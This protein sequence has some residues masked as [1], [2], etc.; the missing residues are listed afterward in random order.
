MARRKKNRTHLKGGVPVEGS[1][2]AN[3]SNAPKSVVV[4]HGQVG[5]ALSQLVRDLRKV[6]EPNTASK[7]RERK[8][9]KM[10]DYLVI[11]PALGVTHIVALTLTPVAPSLRIMRLSAGPTLSFRIERYSL[12]RDL[13][14]TSRHARS[15]GMEYLSPPLLVLASF[16]PPGPGTPPH[17]SLVQKFFQALFPPLSPHAIS[18][19]SA[20][21][22]VLISYNSETK[23][24]SIRH[25]LIGVRALGVTRHIRK[26][27]EGKA[28]ASHKLLDL[29]REKDLADYILRAPG[30]PGPDGYESASS[31]ASDID[32]EGGIAEVHLAGDYVGR[33]NRAGSKRAVKLT[34]I[35][36]R[37]ELRL[38]KIT[39]GVPGKQGAV[40]YHEFVKKTAAETAELKRA[41]AARA[42]LK[43]ER[44][45]QQARN[46]EQKK[47]AKSQ[48]SGKSAGEVRSKT[49]E[50]GEEEEEEEEEEE[51]EE[52]SID[53]EVDTEDVDEWDENDDVSEGSD[54]DETTEP[55]EDES[56]TE[57]PRPTKRPR[58]R[59]NVPKAKIRV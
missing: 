52:G 2:S 23:T 48:A 31:A 35:G 42:K 19:S 57:P 55:S 49:D 29:G 30:D 56:T 9:N 51:D 6:M 50:E 39:E 18:L 16:P 40:L 46:V 7:L 17:L 47:M 59:G 25:Y 53:H 38:V 13:L 41:A 14:N 28:S 15:M 43:Q 12:T 54:E 3:T 26:L 21:R 5:P 45:E 44:R 37:L 10:K 22:V 58:A 8:R 24:I 20:R 4:K 32:G 36:P 11:A 33:N 1:S 34:E 27:V